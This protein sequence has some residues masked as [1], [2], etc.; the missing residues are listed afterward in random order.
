MANREALH[1]ARVPNPFLKAAE[2][3]TDAASRLGVA[4]PTMEHIRD[5][6]G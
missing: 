5:R 1:G 4:V 3:C 2:Q 6:N